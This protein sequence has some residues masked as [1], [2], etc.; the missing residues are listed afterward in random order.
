VVL[1]P[2]VVCE[3]E[4]LN[5]E[6][7]YYG[8]VYL[9]SLLI[10]VHNFL[11]GD[12]SF[13]RGEEDLLYH[14]DAFYFTHAQFRFLSHEFEKDAIGILKLGIDCS[15]KLFWSVTLVGPVFGTATQKAEHFIFIIIYSN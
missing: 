9:L 10:D 7:F 6:F 11:L 3:E 1:L 14:F 4:V 5:Q 15:E 12:F 2:R 13:V 8:F